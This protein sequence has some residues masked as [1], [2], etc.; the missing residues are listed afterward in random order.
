MDLWG[1]GPDAADTVVAGAPARIVVRL[2]A[3]A[4]EWI[5]V[6]RISHAAHGGELM[7]ALLGRLAAAASRGADPNFDYG[8]YV[9]GELAGWSEGPV[10]ADSDAGRPPLRFLQEEAQGMRLAALGRTWRAQDR[11]TEL[12]ATPREPSGWRHQR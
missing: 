2:G 5:E 10:V 1:P 3:A 12:A 11:L 4:G 7:R 9:R 6:A 8:R